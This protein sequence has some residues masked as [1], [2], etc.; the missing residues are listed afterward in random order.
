METEIAMLSFNIDKRYIETLEF[1]LKRGKSSYRR[2]PVS[3]LFNT[4]WTPAFAGVTKKVEIQ[5][6]H[7]MYR[8]IVIFLLA[9][10]IPGSA[11]AEEMIGKGE[12][13]NLD[14]CIEIALKKHPQILAALSTLDVNKSKVGQA[15]A[16]YYPQITN[17]LTACP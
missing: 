2:K 1:L 8:F 3:S 7:V 15:L 16:G 9:F 11:W 6:S 10:T 12:R 5:G 13:L 17:I 14:K 4:F